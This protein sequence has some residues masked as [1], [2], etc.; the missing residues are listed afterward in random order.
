MNHAQL[1][2]VLHSRW[3]LTVDDIQVLTGGMNSSAWKVGVDGQPLAAKLVHASDR[4]AFLT[5]LFAAGVVDAA[6]VPSGIA[7]ATLDGALWADVPGGA[8]GLLSWVDGMALVGDQRDQQVM[9]DTLGQAHTALVS[10]GPADTHAF[11]PIDLDA[12]HLDVEGWV[13]PAVRDALTHWDAV[14]SEI[15]TWSLLHGDPAPE[16]FLWSSL[17]GTCGLIDW[18]SACYGPALYD[19]ASAVM[20]VGG[21]DRAAPLLAAYLEHGL[22]SKDELRLGL[23][24]MVGLRW[25]VQ[26]DYFARRIRA[27]NLTGI[28]DRRGNT[29]GLHDAR[30][31]LTC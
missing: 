7:V 23:R 11:R 2:S 19:L 13:R 9:G 27:D 30:R 21:P 24:S 17:R 5:G 16:A 14:A 18:S 12:A 25:A 6:G 3:G 28:A 22:L 31:H 29:K 26:A 10:A 8:L 20:Y 4:A 15:T 1:A